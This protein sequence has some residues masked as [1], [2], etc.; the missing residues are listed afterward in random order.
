MASVIPLRFRLANILISSDWHNVVT[1]FGAKGD[2][3]TDDTAAIQAAI[4]WTTSDQR[5]TIYFPTGTYKVTSSII[6]PL[7]NGVITFCLL[8]DGAATTVTGDVDGFI[9]IRQA[10]TYDNPFTQ[11]V[12]IEGLNVTNQSVTA[13]TGAIYLG[14]SA[15]VAARDCTI[16]GVLGLVLNENDLGSG[17]AAF[18]NASS[19]P[20]EVMDCKFIP[21]SGSIVSGSCAIA[22]GNQ[23]AI[24]NCEINGYHKGIAS[25]GSPAS[26]QV[27]G[28]HIKECNYGIFSGE[29]QFGNSYASGL[30]VQ[31]IELADNNTAGLFCRAAAVIGSGVL[32]HGNGGQYGLYFAGGGGV[33]QST[34]S[35]CTVDGS[36]STAA[37][38]IDDFPAQAGGAANRLNSFIGCMASNSGAGVAWHMPDNA[39]GVRFINSNNPSPLVTFLTLPVTTGDWYHPVIGDEY[40]VSDSPTAAS[41]HFYTVVATGGSSNNV[42]LRWD[43]SAWRI[44]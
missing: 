37:I 44:V 29:D 33:S 24:I 4:N 15:F 21:N 40:L 8:G 17:I 14:S 42:K 19:F 41:G 3:V 6:L 25:I 34:F 30:V 23:G 28:G 31:G 22:T 5:G 36:Y 26:V 35:S 18:P 13:G 1:D 32:I 11:L 2:G 16:S 9:F 10:P 20:F 38:M 43:G 27:I 7:G 39:P 12:A